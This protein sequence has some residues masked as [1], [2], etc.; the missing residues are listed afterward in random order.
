MPFTPVIPSSYQTNRADLDEALVAIVDAFIAS[1]SYAIGRKSASALPDLLTGE[2]PLIVVGDITEAIVHT[3]QLRITTFTGSILYVDWITDRQEYASR[4]NV[5]ADRMRDLFT[6]N[7]ST[8]NPNAELFQTGFSEG[9]ITL[10]NITL[11]APE[12]S[13]KYVIQEGYQ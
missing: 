6:Y 4:V 1:E 13:F 3:M 7:R 5:F 8:V 9:D 11:G 12:L 2:G 10:G